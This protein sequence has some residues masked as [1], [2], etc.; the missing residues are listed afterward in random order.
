MNM[1]LWWFVQNT[2]AVAL[3]IPIVAGVC[4]LCRN[5]PAV[6]HVL[7]AV[8][9][10]KFITPPLLCWPG[11]VERLSPQIKSILNLPAPSGLSTLG[12]RIGSGVTDI[13]TGSRHAV[14]SGTGPALPSTT[15]TAQSCRPHPLYSGIRSHPAV[16][17]SGY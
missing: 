1:L 17:A 3:L 9:L 8:V 5:R 16:T 10:L 4:C 12:R 11:S 6:Q 15:V 13:S 7:W 2:I 14:A